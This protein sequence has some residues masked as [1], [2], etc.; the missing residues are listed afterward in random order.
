[1]ISVIIATRNRLGYLREAVASVQSQSFTEWELIVVDDCSQDG[2]WDWL[3]SLDDERIRALR[4]QQHRERSAARNAGLR[5]ARGEYVLFLDD[6]DWLLGGALTHLWGALQAQ[7]A[8]IAAAGARWEVRPAGWRRVS[9]PRRGRLRDIWEDVMFGWAPQCGQTLLRKSAVLEAGAWQD[10]FIP[11][12]DH[13][14][15]SRFSR[16]GPV[17]LIGQPVLAYRVHQGQ[18]LNA[19]G[20]AMVTLRR[21]AVAK[22]DGVEGR[23]AERTLLAMRH[24][25]LSH[26]AFQRAR[27]VLAC[28]HW[29]QSVRQAPWLLESPLCRPEITGIGLR[30]MAG[31]VLGERVIRR[32]RHFKRAMTDAF[33]RRASRR[34]PANA[35]FG[36]NPPETP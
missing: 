24:A 10:R 23:R 3:E 21:A 15:W 18:S 1:V 19:T 27:Y 20:L 12:E 4:M 11:A 14:F 6:D 33:R 35:N 30:C 9:H 16:L 17:V 5:A 25:R 26:R 29:W 32:L 34:V 7:N 2:T 31:L 28:R 8:A 22:L 36:I 13:G